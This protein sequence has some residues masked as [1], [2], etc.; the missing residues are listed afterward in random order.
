MLARPL[1]HRRRVPVAALCVV[2]TTIACSD[3][4][5]GPNPEPLPSIVSNFDDN[6]TQGWTL[7]GAGPGPNV[8]PTLFQSGKH[9]IWTN[10]WNNWFKAPPAYLGD[11]SGY[12][13]AELSY[14][15]LWSNPSPASLAR[16]PGPEIE[17]TGVNGLTI[18]LR[19]LDGLPPNVR[20]WKH[21]TVALREGAGWLRK[22]DGLPV[23][24]ADIE[25]VLANVGEIAL[26]AS[27]RLTN[28]DNNYID[29]VRLDPTSGR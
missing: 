17:I 7:R 9:S 20:E 5:T 28:G 22:A 16:D 29:E 11:K 27:R 23:T 6:T 26:R 21:Y 1:H 19:H 13:G 4:S 12:Y 14:W 15:Y 18:T 2:A 25:G 10:G 3:S 24:R 8:H